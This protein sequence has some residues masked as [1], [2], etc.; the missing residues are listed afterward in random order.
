VRCSFLKAAIRASHGNFVIGKSALRRHQRVVQALQDSH[1]RPDPPESVAE[2][3]EFASALGKSL[4][5]AFIDA[6]RCSGCVSS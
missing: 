6:S 4:P 5:I 3:L 1:G 2:L